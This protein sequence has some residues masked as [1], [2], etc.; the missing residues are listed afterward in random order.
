MFHRTLG[1]F[2]AWL[3]SLS[4]NQQCQRTAEVVACSKTAVWCL[5][6]DAVR[7]ALNV[8]DVETGIL[9]ELCNQYQANFDEVLLRFLLL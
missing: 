4:A 8:R 5:V 6:I 2:T 1:I 9:R 7:I 3:S